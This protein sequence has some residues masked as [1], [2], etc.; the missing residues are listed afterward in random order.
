MGRASD[1]LDVLLD[2]KHDFSKG[3]DKK[4]IKKER[5]PT[6]DEINA[7]VARYNATGRV[8]YVYPRKKKV[9]LDGYRNLDFTSA[10][11]YMKEVV[12]DK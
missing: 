10:M 5:T 1:L 11:K 12:M 2:G 4:P 7:M 6:L 8:A 3:L 9:G